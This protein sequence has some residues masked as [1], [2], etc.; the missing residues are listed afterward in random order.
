MSSNWLLALV[1]MG[2]EKDRQRKP[3]TACQQSAYKNM[4]A[5]LSEHQTSALIDKKDHITK[6][7]KIQKF[8]ELERQN[9]IKTFVLSWN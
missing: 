2:F 4:W 6:I 1:M 3:P 7:R 9:E 8:R 5:M